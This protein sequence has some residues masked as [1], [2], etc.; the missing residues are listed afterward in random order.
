MHGI[1]K[2]K[3]A[4]RFYIICY[5][6]NEIKEIGV[7]RE[8]YI[9]S[10]FPLMKDVS[11]IYIGKYNNQWHDVLSEYNGEVVINYMN[12]TPM[13]IR[14]DKLDKLDYTDVNIKKI[15]ELWK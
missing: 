3:T 4:L 14:K 8:E 10:S 9:K 2:Y 15:D 13:I 7:T 12:R 1:L 11:I 5:I 6:D